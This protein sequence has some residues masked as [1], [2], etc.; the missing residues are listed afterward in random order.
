MRTRVGRR[1]FRSGARA[2]RLQIQGFQAGV[3]GRSAPPLGAARERRDEAFRPG[4][5]GGSAA[6]CFATRKVKLDHTKRQLVRSSAL[7][8][9]S[10][11][12][13]PPPPDAIQ[14]PQG[15]TSTI[16]NRRKSTCRRVV[17]LIGLATCA[18][19]A[20]G[21]QSLRFDSIKSVQPGAEGRA[22]WTF[23]I[24]AENPLMRVGTA[25]EFPVSMN[26]ES[27]R[28]LDPR[29]ASNRYDV[30]LTAVL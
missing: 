20:P 22:T 23:G 25:L 9:D 26:A 15:F 11:G 4:C 7:P 21:V 29:R 13:L 19:S 16:A 18:M 5:G 1:Y 2:A 27:I 24:P 3:R 28:A 10:Y 12:G 14:E 17:P 6:K 8:T 30:C